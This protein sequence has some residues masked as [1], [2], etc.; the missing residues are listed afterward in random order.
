[1]V[2]G[3]EF[4]SNPLCLSGLLQD[5]LMPR[6]RQ[7][8]INPPKKEVLQ[9]LSCLGKNLLWMEEILRNLIYP[10]VTIVWGAS[11]PP[12]TAR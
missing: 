6:A 2:E 8:L 1:M 5:E 3:F 4:V 12:S 9:K 10:D 11:V 7:K